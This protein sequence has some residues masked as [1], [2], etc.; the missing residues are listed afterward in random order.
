VREAGASTQGDLLEV[1][2]LIVYWA[3]GWA[4]WKCAR[5]V[6]RPVW[7]YAARAAVIGG[8]GLLVLL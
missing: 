7:A 1:V 6:S 4:V 3:W 5:N 8:L 2:R